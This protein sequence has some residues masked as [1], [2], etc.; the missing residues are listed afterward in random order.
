MGEIEELCMASEKGDLTTIHKILDKDPNLVNKRQ[1]FG[2]SALHAS[3]GNGHEV[4][5]QYL[6]EMGTDINAKGMLRKLNSSYIL[7][8]SQ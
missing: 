7:I 2:H 3:A 5:V 8:V 1:S 4:I 6:A